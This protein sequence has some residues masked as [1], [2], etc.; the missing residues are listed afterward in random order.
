[1]PVPEGKDLDALMYRLLRMKCP[2]VLASIILCLLWTTTV[3]FNEEYEMLEFF[4]GAGNLS[5]YMVALAC[6]FKCRPDRFMAMFA[7]KCASW[8][9]IN[10]GTSNRAPCASIGFDEYP[11]V[12]E[13][14]A[15]CERTIYLLVV[16][17]CL[18]GVFGL[19]QPRL[20]NFEF[21]PM[22]LE[23][24][25]LCYE[26]NG[27]SS[28]VWRVGWW[29]AHYQSLSP[30]R[31]YAFSN[32]QVIQKLDRGKLSGWKKK[33]KEKLQTTIQYQSADGKRCFKGTAA[34]RKTEEYTVQFGRCLADLY[35][36]MVISPCGQPK[37]PCL[38]PPAQES[39]QFMGQG[40]DLGYARLNEVY[41]YLR[42]GRN[43]KIPPGWSHLLPKP[44]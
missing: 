13:A 1:M 5:R 16:V 18:G 2:K 8:T 31:H 38:L 15:L 35:D 43:L 11:N 27:G 36:E 22:F 6:L 44:E 32:S 39:Y 17:V 33:G 24:R 7:L 30:K 41:S 10:S 29:M 26:V 25:G 21:Y 42:R 23:F 12:L 9:A 14:N 20:S 40:F 28:A 3:D 37:L 19:E 34:L 4:A